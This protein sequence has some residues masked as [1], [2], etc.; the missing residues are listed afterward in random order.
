MSLFF[1]R[2]DSNVFDSCSDWLGVEPGDSSA[3][4]E[5]SRGGGL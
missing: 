4:V 2:F 1:Q 5:V 3:A